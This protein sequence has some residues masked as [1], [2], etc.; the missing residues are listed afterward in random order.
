MTPDIKK[1]VDQIEASVRL[2]NL[3]VSKEAHEN[4][5]AMLEG[6]KTYEELMDELIKKFDHRPKVQ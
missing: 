5:V 6:K 1:A 2:E 3:P 4:L